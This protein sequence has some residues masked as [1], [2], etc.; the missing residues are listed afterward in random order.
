MKTAKLDALATLPARSAHM[1]V[2]TDSTPQRA[3]TTTPAHAA[4]NLMTTDQLCEFLQVSRR[5]V[6]TWRAQ[7]NGPAY[8]R[9]GNSVRYRP[10]DVDAWLSRGLV[11]PLRDA[12]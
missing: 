8:V 2:M 11:T 1:S 5:T 6:A 3:A 10:Q 7:H 9:L 12:A 4:R